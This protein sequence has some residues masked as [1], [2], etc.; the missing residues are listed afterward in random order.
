MDEDTTTG[1]ANS[2]PPNW[3]GTYIIPRGGGW[4]A[5]HTSDDFWSEMNVHAVIALTDNPNGDPDEI[6]DEFLKQ[7]GFDEHESRFSF[8]TLIKMS[9]DLILHLRYLHTFQDL[10][11]QI[12]MPS[13]NWFR[14]DTFVPGAC[15]KI[16]NTVVE[17]GMEDILRSERALATAMARSHLMEAE[18]LPECKHTEFILSSYRWALNFAEW[19]EQTWTQLLESAPLNRAEC[20][21]LLLQRLKEDSMVPLSVMD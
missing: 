21:S 16:A 8:A 20:K 11:K 15:A 13:H 17:Q 7:S 6:L 14:D 2:V 19:T 1:L 9:G 4:S 3:A 18:S 5:D 12:W 10:T